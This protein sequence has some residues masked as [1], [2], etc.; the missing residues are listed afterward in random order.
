M[1]QRANMLFIK[2][3]NN[4]IFKTATVEEGRSMQCRKDEVTTISRLIPYFIFH[5]NAFSS[6]IFKVTVHNILY[7]MTHSSNFYY[8]SKD[9]E[10]KIQKPDEV[11]GLDW[12]NPVCANQ[13]LLSALNSAKVCLQ[14]FFFLLKTLTRPC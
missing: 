3:T 8:M 10:E 6:V 1:T 12:F 11:A 5:S 4:T 14:A 9:S 2:Q 7:L 13:R